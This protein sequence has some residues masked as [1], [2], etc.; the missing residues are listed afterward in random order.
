[1]L[2]VAKPVLKD[3]NKCTIFVIFKLNLCFRQKYGKYWTLSIYV[4]SFSIICTNGE[5]KKAH[6]SRDSGNDFWVPE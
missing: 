1:M 3:R 4:T 6:Y 5:Q 2:M